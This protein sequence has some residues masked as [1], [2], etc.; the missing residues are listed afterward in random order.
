MPDVGHDAGMSVL[1]SRRFAKIRDKV[2][3]WS[4]IIYAWVEVPKYVPVLIPG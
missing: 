4:N 2:Q 1:G 3:E